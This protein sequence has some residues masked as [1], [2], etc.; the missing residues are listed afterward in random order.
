MKD[1][2]GYI[3]VWSCNC[4]H[5]RSGLISNHSYK[6]IREVLDDH[7]SNYQY[8]KKEPQYGALNT[9]VYVQSVPE[10][11]NQDNIAIYI[12]IK[13]KI[14]D[15]FERQQQ[16]LETLNESEIRNLVITMVFC[17]GF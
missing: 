11:E 16:L 8:S 17:F 12:P 4:S 10:I 3:Q 15:F 6:N 9:G 14:A 1:F 5:Y 13:Y 2:K 7:I